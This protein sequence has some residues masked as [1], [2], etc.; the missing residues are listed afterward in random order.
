MTVSSQLRSKLSFDDIKLIFR[1]NPLDYQGL[2]LQAKTL[3]TL[4]SNMAFDSR[5]DVGRSVDRIKIGGSAA[6]AQVAR[7]TSGKLPV[8]VDRNWPGRNRR[9]SPLCFDDSWAEIVTDHDLE[10]T[11]WLWASSEP[12]HHDAEAPTHRRPSLSAHCQRTAPA[13]AL[14]R[15]AQG[16][17]PGSLNHLP[18][19]RRRLVPTAGAPWTAC[20]GLALVGPGSLDAVSRRHAPLRAA[21][22]AG[23][24]AGAARRERTLGAACGA[25]RSGSRAGGRSAPCPASPSGG[26][27]TLVTLAQRSISGDLRCTVGVGVA[28]AT[29]RV[30]S[31]LRSIMGSSRCACCSGGLYRTPGRNRA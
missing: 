10:Q 22:H 4:H 14:A 6:V 2:P 29:S 9:Q 16:H 24:R 3:R 21:L 7:G 11:Y 5:A 23:S 17:R 8:A 27:D 20:R 1:D 26:E 15:R 12:S 13:R 18:L 19:D 31:L 30:L 28:R 25:P